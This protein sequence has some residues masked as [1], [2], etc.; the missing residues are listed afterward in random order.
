MPNFSQVGLQDMNTLPLN[1][2]SGLLR[3]CH[4]PPSSPLVL[5]TGNALV[6]SGARR[7]ALRVCALTSNEFR[8]GVCIELEGA[9]WKIVGTRPAP[10]S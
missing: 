2:A 1:T 3:A 4:V 9:P 5:L 8:P 6:Q 10:C 7:A